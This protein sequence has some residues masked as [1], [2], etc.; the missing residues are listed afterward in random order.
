MSSSL[1]DYL[2]KLYGSKKKKNESKKKTPVIKSSSK[3]G[4]M[5]NLDNQIIPLTQS[6]SNGSETEPK[7]KKKKTWINLNT[8]E[9]QASTSPMLNVTDDNLSLQVGKEKEESTI[10][11][12]YPKEIQKSNSQTLF[13]DSKGH[14]IKNYDSFMDELRQQELSEKSEKERYLKELNMGDIQK[15]LIKVSDA[16]ANATKKKHLYEIQDVEDPAALF[17][18]GVGGKKPKDKRLSVLGRM[19]YNKN[20]PENRFGVVPGWRW[21]GI[22]RS[23]GF[24]NRWFAKKNEIYEKKIQDYTLQQDF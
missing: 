4:I 7:R 21:D 6:V 14:K 13:R 18:K 16:N 15:N 20:Y 1:N 22:D 2:S 19:Q 11:G 12:T 8:N 9:I 3:I 24:E 23:T 17:T 10:Q 5:D